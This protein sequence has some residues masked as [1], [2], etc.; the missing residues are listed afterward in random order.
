MGG[1]LVGGKADEGPGLHFGDFGFGGDA[2]A[3]ADYVDAVDVGDGGVGVDGGPLGNVRKSGSDESVEL[4]PCLSDVLEG[5]VGGAAGDEL[6]KPVWISD[7][8]C[9]RKSGRCSY[10]AQRPE[11]PKQEHREL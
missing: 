3:V 11:R 2:G 4:G 10:S 9:L 8:Y 6:G 1:G 5:W 7:Q